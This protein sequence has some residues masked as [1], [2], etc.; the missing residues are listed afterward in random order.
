MSYIILLIYILKCVIEMVEII[1]K[2]KKFFF[3]EKLIIVGIEWQS[4]I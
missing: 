4:L 2:M 3:C 1:K